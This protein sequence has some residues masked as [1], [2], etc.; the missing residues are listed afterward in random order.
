MSNSND[1]EYRLHIPDTIKRLAKEARYYTDNFIKGIPWDSKLTVTGGGG[2]IDLSGAFAH[3]T[4]RELDLSQLDL[5][6]KTFTLI[7]MGN[8]HAITRVNNIYVNFTNLNAGDFNE[9]S[10]K[11]H[12]NICNNTIFVYI[13][14]YNE[15]AI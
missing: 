10:D 6:N 5:D 9:K 3:L 15:L 1:L 12:N 2:L 8:P 14:I 4:L 7:S 11:K 13:N